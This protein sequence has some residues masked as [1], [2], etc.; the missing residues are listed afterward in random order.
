MIYKN[1]SVVNF[2]SNNGKIVFSNNSAGCK[3]K[4]SKNIIVTPQEVN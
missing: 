2:T 1:S 3:K 4:I